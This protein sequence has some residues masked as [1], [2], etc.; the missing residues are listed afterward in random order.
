MTLWR[1]IR[2]HGAP[3]QLFANFVGFEHDAPRRGWRR[4]A[5]RSAASPI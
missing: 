4:A 5:S 3:R 2:E 1:S